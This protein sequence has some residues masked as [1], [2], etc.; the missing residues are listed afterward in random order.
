M[1]KNLTLR[2][3]GGEELARKLKLMGTEASAALELAA[4]TGMAVLESAAEPL[5]PGPHLVSET[6][7]RKQ[8]VATVEMGP[9]KK[10]WYYRFLEYGAREH[11]IEGNPYLAFEGSGGLMVTKKV[12]HPGMKAR[13]FLRPAFDG[14]HRQAKKNTG[15][16]LRQV[17]LRGTR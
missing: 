16:V 3:E 5:A 4:Q 6:T 13:P 1:G 12:Q 15:Q 7:E 11:E 10:H 17:I 2:V 14:R 8:N 9:D